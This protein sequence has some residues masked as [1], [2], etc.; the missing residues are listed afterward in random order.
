[1]DVNDLNKLHSTQPAERD[2]LRLRSLESMDADHS[3]WTRSHLSTSIIEEKQD[4]NPLRDHVTL[5]HK[6][7][8]MSE[9]KKR[10]SWRR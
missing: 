7:H 4:P 1:M 6:Y 10:G 3:E 5:Y 9:H 2:K 8:E